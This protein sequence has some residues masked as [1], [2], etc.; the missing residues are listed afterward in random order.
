MYMISYGLH[1]LLI[2]NSNKE[3]FEELKVSFSYKYVFFLF[4][5]VQH[6]FTYVPLHLW[7]NHGKKH[8]IT[9]QMACTFKVLLKN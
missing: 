7:I 9:F 2:T 1:K 5:L 8:I 6:F 3:Y 4:L